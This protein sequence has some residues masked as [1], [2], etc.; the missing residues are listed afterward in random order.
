MLVI[1]K[2]GDYNMAIASER[3]TIEANVKGFGAYQ[4]AAG[5]LLGELYL[6]IQEKFKYPIAAGIINNTLRDLHYKLDSDC[7]VE[8]VDT[9]TEAGLRIYRRSAA[10]LLIKACKDLFP[11]RTL[12]IKHT[13]SNGL[14][15]EFLNKTTTDNEIE[16]IQD[17]MREI[18]SLDLPINKYLLENEEAKRIFAGQNQDDKV[19]L[20]RYRD[21]EAAHVYELDGFIEYFYGYM[22]Y[23]T[24]ILNRFKLLYLS[25]GIILR[26]PEKDDIDLIKPY[27]EQ[28]K[29]A[30]I[31][32]E[33]KEWVEML[34]MPHLAALN[35]IITL[36]NIDDIIRVNEALHEKKIAYIADSI[37]HNPAIRLVSIAGPSSSG[38]TTFAQRLLIQLRV[39]GRRPVSIS[40]D[41]YF[42]DRNRTPLDEKGNLNF[43]SLE[44][45]D[46]DLFNEHLTRLINGEEVEIPVYNFKT[47]NRE[48]LDVKIKV[49]A[50]EPIIIEGIHGLNERL[51][52]SIP[53]IN[54]FQIYISALTQLNVDYS[55]RIPTTDSRLI[56]RIIRD[57]RTR[58]YSARNT[59]RQWPSV[60]RGEERYIFPFQENADVM[61][62]SSLVYELSVLK[63][64]AEPLL[65]AIDN[66][67]PE[68]VEASRLLRF[69]SYF[70]AIQPNNIPPNSILRE[71]IGG[72]WFRD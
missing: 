56:R 52:W 36:G 13:L 1:C 63:L 6:S 33:A 71:F 69:L 49:P 58:G 54:K 35:E 45:L 2:E 42:V 28:K 19:K 65:E 17:R 32:Q 70:R 57:S 14:Y 23:R 3:N 5:T 51:T 55:N 9:S 21:K 72:S 61:F 29:L 48:Y 46:I 24:G 41:N 20:M 25:G 12:M 64:Y 34:R 10:F 47:G 22:V 11:E 27:H 44:A 43:E 37:C 62:N 53:R 16:L 66:D 4:V 59:I 68:H 40:L 50:G 67:Q 30:I 38:K 31:H 8:L 60:R 39:N 15:C 7:D 26:T 18:V